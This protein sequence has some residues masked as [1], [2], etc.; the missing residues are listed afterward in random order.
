MTTQPQT[1]AERDL[2]AALRASLEARA[3]WWQAQANQPRRCI[4]CGKDAPS[5]LHEG[6]SPPCG[7]APEPEHINRPALSGLFHF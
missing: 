2:S 7:C 4:S 3:L 6:E 1:R 5:V